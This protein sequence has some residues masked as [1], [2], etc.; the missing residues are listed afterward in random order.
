M[1]HKD[2]VDGH[3]FRMVRSFTNK[4][5][6]LQYVAYYNEGFKIDAENFNLIENEIVD[7]N[8]LPKNSV[9]SIVIK[10]VAAFFYRFY[11]MVFFSSYF[12]VWSLGFVSKWTFRFLINL[13]NAQPGIQ[14]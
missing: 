7:P 1:K 12:I 10:I 4:Q 3:I 2:T 13:I 9:F 6:N 8:N 5:H 14:Q 11:L